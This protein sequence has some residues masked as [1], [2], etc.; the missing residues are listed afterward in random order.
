MNPASRPAWVTRVTREPVI[1]FP[2]KPEQR[3]LTLA[4]ILA[5]LLAASCATVR[6]DYYRPE[7]CHALK[8]EARSAGALRTGSGYVATGL[9]AGGALASAVGDSRPATIALAVGA[10]L[11]GALGLGADSYEKSAASEWDEAC[12]VMPVPVP[13]P[14]RP[15]ATGFQAP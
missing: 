1:L 13:Q 9:A 10:V 4:M 5:A 12:S 3:P 14:G 11:A 6:P 2:P 8:R 15:D 7:D